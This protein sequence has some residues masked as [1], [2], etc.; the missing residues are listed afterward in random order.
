MSQT[1]STSPSK[2]EKIQSKSGSQA[3]NLSMKKWTCLTISS[4]MKVW[5]SPDWN[6]SLP[7]MNCLGS[8]SRILRIARNRRRKTLI[9]MIK[10][11]ARNPME[12]LLC[13]SILMITRR[14]FWGIGRPEWGESSQNRSLS[15]KSPSPKKKNQLVPSHRWNP[16]EETWKSTAWGQAQT[17][18]LEPE[19]LK[20]TRSL[21]K[22]WR[23]SRSSPITQKST[24]AISFPT[25]LKDSDGLTK[26]TREI[27]QGP[28]RIRQFGR[29]WTNSRR[30]RNDTSKSLFI[31]KLIKEQNN[32][33]I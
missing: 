20:T 4:L 1:L 23:W 10:A 19:A 14:N 26:T 31:S 28:A 22:M 21:K 3:R 30:P 13:I 8:T 7:N 12:N 11:V 24:I 27:Y 16:P 32:I 33:L 18:T 5:R 15:K 17:S 9:L 29:S 25:Q 6:N 2:K